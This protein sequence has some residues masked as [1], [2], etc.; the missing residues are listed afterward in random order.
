MKSRESRRGEYAFQAPALPAALVQ[1]D[2]RLHG[3]VELVRRSRHAPG[4]STGLKNV[5]VQPTHVA[6]MRFGKPGQILIP[7]RRKLQP[8]AVRA[9]LP[10]H[11]ASPLSKLI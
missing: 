2:Q 5:A 4:P 11:S 6:T 10:S 9:G 1:V 3:A 7:R 8:P